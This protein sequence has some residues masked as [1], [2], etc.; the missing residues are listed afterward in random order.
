M[1]SPNR[2]SGNCYK[3]DLV[4]FCSKMT[5]YSWEYLIKLCIV[6][7]FFRRKIEGSH[8]ICSSDIIFED[9]IMAEELSANAAKLYDGL[10]WLLNQENQG[11]HGLP[12]TS[13]DCIVLYEEPSIISVDVSQLSWTPVIVCEETSSSIEL[14]PRLSDDKTNDDSSGIPDG[15]ANDTAYST[16]SVASGLRSKKANPLKWNKVANQKLREVGEAYTGIR[17]TKKADN[18]NFVYYLALS[19]I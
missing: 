11:H 17:R 2:S 18:S 10:D 14:N 13:R 8:P 9:C 3:F 12:G 4:S 15:I 5:I 19:C 7:I 6:E 16:E 1:V